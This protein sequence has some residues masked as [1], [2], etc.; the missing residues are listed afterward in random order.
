[1]HTRTHLVFL[2]GMNTS[3]ILP[4]L[5]I[6]LV[7]LSNEGDKRLGILRPARSWGDSRVD[8]VLQNVGRG[9]GER[10][11]VRETDRDRDREG[12]EGEGE[13]EGGRE[14]GGR[15]GRER[16]R[17]RG[18]RWRRERGKEREGKK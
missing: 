15:E 17:E 6:T 16:R 3:L 5:N 2:H 9:R 12:G 8:G 4:V 13:S 7:H 11:R 10:E 18:G 14:R 1:M